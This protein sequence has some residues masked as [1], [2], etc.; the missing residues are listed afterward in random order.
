[1]RL[2]LLVLLPLLSISAPHAEAST[3]I[4]EHWAIAKNHFEKR[5][6][7]QG[8]EQLEKLVSEHPNH[9]D[10][11]PIG[12]WFFWEASKRLAGSERSALE[13]RAE[14]FILAGLPANQES[15]FYHRELGDFYRLRVGS[16]TKS[17]IHYQQAVK[18]F[19]SASKIQKAALLDRLARSSE[20]L[21][22]KGDA[23]TASCRALEFDPD[24]KMA[25]ARI[26]NLAGNCK[27]KGFNLDL[28]DESADAP[29]TPTSD[30]A[31]SR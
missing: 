15:W 23:V 8:A 18:Y 28:E 4:K 13:A 30:E 7:L 17:H 21:G 26:K 11:R 31:T 20:E 2:Q 6:Y 12:A 16:T 27:R 25:Q 3:T 24:D 19:E 22:R 10:A 29:K 1:M 5:E 9:F 14:A